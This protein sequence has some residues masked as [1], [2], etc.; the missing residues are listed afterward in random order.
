V[1]IH[2][3]DE[4]ASSPV[5]AAIFYNDCQYIVHH[6]LVL[7]QRYGKTLSEP[8]QE[9]MTFTDLIPAFR[10]LGQTQLYQAL[11]S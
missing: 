9:M 7:G 1:P 10:S 4:L 2:W 5:R 11:V 8:M 3:A 6:L